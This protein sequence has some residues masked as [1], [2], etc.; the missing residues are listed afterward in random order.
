[1]NNKGQMGFAGIVIVTVIGILFLVVGTQIV[2]TSVTTYNATSGVAN[3]TV[4]GGVSN[5]I[6][7]NLVPFM[8]LGGLALAGTLAFFAFR[9]R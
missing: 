2:A 8:L 7:Q 3:G 6:A 1:M 4:F 5:T 9:G